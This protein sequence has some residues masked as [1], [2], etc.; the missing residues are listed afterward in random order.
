MFH[1]SYLKNNK[2][3]HVVDILFCDVA[4]VPN[5]VAPDHVSAHQA[6]GCGPV[7]RFQG[8]RPTQSLSYN[9]LSLPFKWRRQ[10]S[11]EYIRQILPG[12]THLTLKITN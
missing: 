9:S 12:G 6:L 3:K 5:D 8:G 10:I 4:D 1:G 11:T 2:S 7:D